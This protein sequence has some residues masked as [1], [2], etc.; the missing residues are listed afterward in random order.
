[1]QFK[2]NKSVTASNAVPASKVKCVAWDLDNTL[3]KGVFIEDG[4]ENLTLN[5]DA[6]E[7]IRRFDERGILNTIVSKNSFDEVFNFLKELGI[8]KYFLYQ[9]LTGVK[10]VSIWLI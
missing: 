4:K 2:T 7:L 10:R 3:W 8:E 9:L 1:M 5:S 6:I